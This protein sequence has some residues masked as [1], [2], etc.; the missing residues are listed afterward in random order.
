[1]T[2]ELRTTIEPTD[3]R[4]I[5]YEC[6]HCHSRH[7]VPIEKFDRVLLQCPNCKEAMA[8][9]SHYPH[10]TKTDETTLVALV[11]ALQNAK[12]LTCKIRFELAPEA[13]GGSAQKSNT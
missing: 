10:T 7:A 2:R 1:M 6:S 11:N 3:I 4:A 13:N 9:P 8:T 5:E 12:D